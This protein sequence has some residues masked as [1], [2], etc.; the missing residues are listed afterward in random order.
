[1]AAFSA[2]RLARRLQDSEGVGLRAL[3]IISPIFDYNSR[4]FEWDPVRLADPAAN[5]GGGAAAGR[6][7]GRRCS[8]VEA[9]ATGDYLQDFIRGMS[10]AAAVQRMSD[11]VAALT[12]LDPAHW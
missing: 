8:D 10:D 2:P 11:K 6:D 1:M 5:D 4:S 7:A 3:A 12:G 9:Y